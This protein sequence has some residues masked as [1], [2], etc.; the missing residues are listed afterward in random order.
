MV[1]DFFFPNVGGVEEH[2][3]NLSMCLLEKGH[4]VVVMTHSYGDRVGSFFNFIWFILLIKNISGVRYM[5][6]GLKVYYLPIQV[7][8]NQCVLPTMI[9][10]IPLIRY[11]LIRERIE[12]I[13]GH[14]AF[15]ALA[16]EALLIGNLMGMKVKQSYF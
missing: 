9:C 5:T 12:I 7:F 1:S 10:N 8:Y 15:S 3:Y 16:H 13:H 11:I 4:K 6:N 14:S 2:I